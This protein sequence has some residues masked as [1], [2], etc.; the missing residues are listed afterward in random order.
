MSRD[1]RVAWSYRSSAWKYHK[2]A[3]AVWYKADRSPF[4]KKI[5][6]QAV[7]HISRK[8]QQNRTCL[9]ISPGAQSQPFEADH[10]VAAPIGKP[11]VAR[12]HRAQYHARRLLPGQFL[13]SAGGRD[14]KLIGGQDQMRPRPSCAAAGLG[15]A[16]LQA[17][18][19]RRRRQQGH[20]GPVSPILRCWRLKTGIRAGNSSAKYPGLTRSST[21]M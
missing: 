2:V 14:D 5:G 10:R 15:Q 1:R 6:N 13:Y 8:C 20:R 21:W 16:D 3:S 19:A 12:D 9:I 18:V 7:F 11:M 4:G 17:D